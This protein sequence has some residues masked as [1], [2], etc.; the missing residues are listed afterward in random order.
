MAIKIKHSSI[1]ATYPIP[2]TGNHEGVLMIPSTDNITSSLN[3]FITGV[4]QS[5]NDLAT[6]QYKLLWIYNEG[7]ENLVDVSL[8]IISQNPQGATTTLQFFN[9][10]GQ[11]SSNPSTTISATYPGNTADGW[12]SDAYIGILPATFAAGVWTKTVGNADIAVA[13]D[14]ITV[15]TSS[16]IE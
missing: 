7:P 1:Q 6:P 15:R 5:A 14:F 4:T 2:Y 16:Q 9:D 3:G 12:D 11:V 10:R 8:N 13:E